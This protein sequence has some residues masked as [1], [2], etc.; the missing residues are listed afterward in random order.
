VV[1][2]GFIVFG[3]ALL[4]SGM[5]DLSLLV[6]SRLTVSSMARE[7]ARAA[8]VTRLGADT[9]ATLSGLASKTPILGVAN[10]RTAFPDGWACARPGNCSIV[11]SATYRDADCPIDPTRCSPVVALDPNNRY[12]VEVT[13]VAFGAEVVTPL[14]RTALGCTDGSAPHCFKPVSATASMFYEWQP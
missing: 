9:D 12:L 1:E 5:F 11:Y 4:I 7:L 14:V 6:N 8:S 2:F 3:L 10:D 13:V